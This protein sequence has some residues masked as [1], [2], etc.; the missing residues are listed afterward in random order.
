MKK[1]ILF[2][3]LFISVYIGIAQ[4]LP[5][6]TPQ[7]ENVDPVAFT[8]YFEDVKQNKQ[9]LHS[10]MVLRNGKVISENWL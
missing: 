5:R 9:E 2:S 8:N 7:A 3:I 1:I 10:L 6:S 4:P